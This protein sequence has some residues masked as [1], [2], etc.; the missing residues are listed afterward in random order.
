MAD[1]SKPAVSEGKVLI[2]VHSAGINPFD[3]KVRAGYM[4]EFIRLT[5]PSTLGGDFSGLA[6][7]VGPAVAGIKRGDPLFGQAYIFGGG[8]GSFAEFA[9]AD[10]KDVAPKPK[11]L[12]HI[13][14]GALPEVGISALQALT[15]HLRLQKGQKILIHGGAGGIGSIAIQLAKH[16][17]ASVAATS[18]DTKIS[19]VKQLGA[20]QI[21]DYKKEKFEE[22]LK[23]YDAV[24][25]TV[26]GETYARSFKVLKRG[27]IIVSMLEQPN[28]ELMKQYGV[29]AVFQSDQVTADR[30]A[31]LARF[32][33]QDVIKVHIEKTFSLDQA[34]E[35]LSYLEEKHPRGKVVLRIKG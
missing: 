13:E 8:S 10:T 30:L 3:W 16:L 22:R 26:G 27:G 32:V 25:D 5:F 12:D 4:K 15:E 33:D 28:Q 1:I 21:V 31:K 34:A 19:Y 6:V 35:A 17:G 2:E 9:L 24:F 14:A 20:D 7:E 23:D 29:A 11:K 18:D